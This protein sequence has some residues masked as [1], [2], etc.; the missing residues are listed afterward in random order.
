[1]ALV[2]LAPSRRGRLL[3][4]NEALCE[5]VGHP[6]ESMLE[7]SIE[8]FVHPDDADGVLRDVELLAMDQLARTEAEVRCL[9]ATAGSS[10][11]P[12]GSCTSTTRP[13]TTSA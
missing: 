3:T 12:P 13:A 11:K 6:A 9:H 5:L 8:S 4:V 2:H 7:T 1:M 10:A